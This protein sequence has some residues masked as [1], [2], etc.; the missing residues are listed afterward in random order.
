MPRFLCPDIILL[1]CAPNSVP[2][3]RLEILCPRSSAAAPAPPPPPLSGAKVGVECVLPCCRTGAPALPPRC[4]APRLEI[5][6][7]NRPRLCRGYGRLCPSSSS[8]SD[9]KSC[10]QTAPGYVRAASAASA[11]PAAASSATPTAASS[12]L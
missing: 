4:R 1:G 6:C 8:I 10:A 11:T 7:P 3:R 9:L 12:L 2:R 5:L